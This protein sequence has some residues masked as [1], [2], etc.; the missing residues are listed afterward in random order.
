M[1]LYAR[2]SS[3]Q[4]KLL[5]TAKQLIRKNSIRCLKNQAIFFT[6]QRYR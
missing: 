1:P 4:T 3:K 6:D 5:A 2:V